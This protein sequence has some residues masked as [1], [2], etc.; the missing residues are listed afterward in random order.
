MPDPELDTQ[1][2]QLCSNLPLELLEWGYD[3]AAYESHIE[4]DLERVKVCTLNLSYSCEKKPHSN[5]IFFTLQ[6][7]TKIIVHYLHKLFRVEP[8]HFNDLIVAR[9][10]VK[11]IGPLGKVIHY[12][13]RIEHG[14]P[15]TVMPGKSQGI[16]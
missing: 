10:V 3:D 15:S 14:Y 13:A 5:A 11:G 9:S 4:L 2:L 8:L 1:F 16:F 7:V 12:V 6:A